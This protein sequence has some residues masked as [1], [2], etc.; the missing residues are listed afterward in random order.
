MY[1]IVYVIGRFV[2]YGQFPYELKST[3][4]KYAAFLDGPEVVSLWLSNSAVNK[5]KTASA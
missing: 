4:G 1:Y 3:I 2:I 5:D